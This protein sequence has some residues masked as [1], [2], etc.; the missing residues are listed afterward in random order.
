MTLEINKSIEILEKTPAVLQ[1]L[2]GGISKGW[3]QNNE[4]DDTWSPFDVV[5]HLVHG[6][7]TD[8]IP[9]LQLIMQHSDSQTFEPYDRFAQFKLS[10]GKSMS[11]LL[12]EFGSCR[13]NNISIL[14]GLNLSEEDLKRKAIHPSLGLVTMKQ[15]IAAWV[16]HDLGHIAQISR[17][18]AK[19]YQ[20][21]IGPWSQ[22]LTIVQRLPKE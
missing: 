11:D 20:T 3:T 16:V 1:H 18:M 8:W 19:Q 21:E 22:Y 12:E 7:K 6:E 13:K 5:G 4:G 9:R 2:L 14:K 17:V 10:E 15:L